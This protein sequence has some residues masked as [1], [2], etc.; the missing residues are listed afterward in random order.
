M[1]LIELHTTEP[2]VGNNKGMI[3]LKSLQYYNFLDFIRTK[4]SKL[5]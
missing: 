4:Q 5:V 1:T 3:L 2:T